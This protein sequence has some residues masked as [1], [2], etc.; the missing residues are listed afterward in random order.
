LKRVSRVLCAVDID[1]RSRQVFAQ[2][3]AI[4]RRRDAQLLIV[5][6]AS[7][8]IAFN[9]G[10][11]E[12]IDFLR[13]L[14][15][16]ADAA[17]L[18]VRVT[19]QRGYA[20]EIILLHAKARRPDLIVVGAGRNDERRGL[21]GSIS[22]RVLRDAPCPTLIVPSSAQPASSFENIVCAVDFSPPSLAAVQEALHL[23]H[24]GRRVMLLHVVD[25]PGP[26]EY[27]HYPWLAIHEYNRGVGAAALDKLRYL[28]PPPKR[29]VVLAQV[30]VGS[31]A[32]EILRTARSMNAHLIV[33]GAQRRNRMSRRLFGRTRAMLR[34]ASCPILAVP[35][36]EAAAHRGE[37]RSRAAA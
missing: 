35:E 20:A 2:A 26:D 29:G 15:A 19:V 5:H 12:R 36:R 30:A 11:T 6:A 9:F 24:E 4:A 1:D 23:A 16:R 13:R 34:D 14:R 8:E 37:E 17:G 32:T 27:S 3:L 18:D 25:G 28:I 7:P 31:P 21:A 22:E 10:A 33:I